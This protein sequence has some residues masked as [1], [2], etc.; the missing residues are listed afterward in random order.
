MSYELGEVKVHQRSRLPH[1][2]VANAIYFVTWRLHDALPADVVA[3]FRHIRDQAVVRIEKER[4]KISPS[5]RFLID[6]AYGH[7]CQDFLDEQHGDCLLRRV[8]CASIVANALEHFDGDRV[9]LYAWVVMP[10]HVHVVLS[11][12]PPHRLSDVLHSL[13]SYTSKEINHVLGQSGS[14]WQRESFDRVV[15]GPKQMLATVRYVVE[16]PAKAGL[17]DWRF[18]RSYPDRIA[19]VI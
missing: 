17:S 4:G 2:D 12:I 5:E 1:W 10:N 8:D 7:A 13:K 18:V 9:L 3:R 16:N 14:V 19:A 11:C 6:R 15:R